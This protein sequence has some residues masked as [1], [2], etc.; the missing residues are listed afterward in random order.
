MHLVVR[1]KIIIVKIGLIISITLIL[2]NGIIFGYSSKYCSISLSSKPSIILIDSAY[3]ATNA[4]FVNTFC[5]FGTWIFVLPFQK[6]MI[7][8]YQICLMLE[9]WSGV[10]PSKSGYALGASWFRM[11]TKIWKEW[12]P[13]NI[14]GFRTN[15][16]IKPSSCQPFLAKMGIPPIQWCLDD[17]RSFF[18]WRWPPTTVEDDIQD[19]MA[20]YDYFYWA[21][22][23]VHDRW[24]LNQP[25][26]QTE[27]LSAIR[28]QNGHTSHSMRPR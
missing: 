18:L 1:P 9:G 2:K 6:V 15:L 4:L 16:M 26:G 7:F 20:S 8:F 27:L 5:W 11:T 23:L 12:P 17:H 14:S 21:T 25:N 3:R 19:H 13:T 24:S 28:S 22:L 10:R